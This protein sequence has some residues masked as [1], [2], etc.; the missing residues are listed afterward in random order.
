MGDASIRRA[1]RGK[2][3]AS[4]TGIARESIRRIDAE[5]LAEICVRASA[6][7]RCVIAWN[8]AG[9]E[10]VARA[11]AGESR[12]DAVVDSALATLSSRLA[13]SNAEA[14]KRGAR[15]S[16]GVAMVSLAARELGAIPE[17]R[18]LFDA[19]LTLHA[20]ASSSEGTTVLV[21][22]ITSTERAPGEVKASLELAIGAVAA[23]LAQAASGGSL[24]FWRERAT[25]NARELARLTKDFEDRLAS[26]RAELARSRELVNRL[27]LRMFAAVDEE[28]A[29]IARDLHD[30]QAQ[31]LA[32]AKIAL[33][34]GGEEARTI[35]KQIEEELRRKTRAI[36]PATLSRA[37]LADSIEHELE[38]LHGAG[39][40]TRFTCGE[41][42]DKLA[43]P[44]QQLCLQVVREAISNVIRHARAHSVEAAIVR[45]DGAIQ[46]SISDDGRGLALRR[47]ASGL[48]GMR[49][50]L[51]LMG[52]QLT[53]QSMARGT[54]VRAE[55]PEPR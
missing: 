14:S 53:I 46:V 10:G 35:F 37:S 4:A 50:R 48:G 22:M 16:N 28:R 13:D 24:E 27:A 12:W 11:P 6:A 33:E 39:V 44:L 17:A 34:G 30:D 15:G 9:V 21:A 32:A 5:A 26:T 42:L 29:K 55:I 23:R 18:R 52:G 45:A 41:G 43:R 36:R 51:E 25:R 40:T 20:S 3:A 1:P 19:R 2:R 31:L 8:Q 7:E 38:R 49:E 54:S 47:D